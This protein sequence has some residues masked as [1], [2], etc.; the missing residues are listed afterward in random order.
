MFSTS[1]SHLKMVGCTLPIWFFLRKARYSHSAHL[2]FKKR[3]SFIDHWPE[4]FRE[5][6]T[7]RWCWPVLFITWPPLSL[8][9]H[10]S[11]FH[12]VSC[13]W[14]FSLTRFGIAFM[15]KLR[16]FSHLCKIRWLKDTLRVFWPVVAAKAWMP[17]PWGNTQ[18]VLVS[19]MESNKS[20]VCFK[21]GLHSEPLSITSE[22]FAL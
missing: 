16:F 13:Q 1:S 9:C 8:V 20:F 15:D 22:I 21:R 12:L 17:K 14:S 6:K 11:L 7:V 18:C 3:D 2:F 10:W 4:I 19:N 5:L